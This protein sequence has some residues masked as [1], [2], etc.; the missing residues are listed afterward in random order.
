M[1]KKNYNDPGFSFK[2]ELFIMLIASFLLIYQK[3]ILESF[4]LI[5]TI[6]TSLKFIDF[7]H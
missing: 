5:N 2:L 3:R 6:A 1:K 7:L 4:P